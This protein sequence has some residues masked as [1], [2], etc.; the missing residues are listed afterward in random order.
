M[1]IRHGDAG[2]NAETGGQKQ[3]SFSLGKGTH[4]T[5]FSEFYSYSISIKVRVTLGTRLFP[6]AST[7]KLM[8]LLRRVWESPG[9]GVASPSSESSWVRWPHI[10]KLWQHNNSCLLGIC[11]A[12]SQVLCCAGHTQVHTSVTRHRP[13]GSSV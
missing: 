4:P 3:V 6:V 2:P 8:R 12:H 9:P 10:L 7:H 5:G 1:V 11:H 13:W